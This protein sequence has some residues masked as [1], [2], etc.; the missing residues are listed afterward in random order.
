MKTANAPMRGRY[1]GPAALLL[2]IVGLTIFASACG[3][4][5]KPGTPSGTY[6][7][8]VTGTGA[9]QTQSTNLTLT[10]Q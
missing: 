10:V 4:S 8:T 2:L 1:L 5:G 6:T 9:G 3:D 7:L